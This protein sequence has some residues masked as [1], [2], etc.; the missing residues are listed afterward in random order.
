MSPRA[1]LSPALTSQTIRRATSPAIWTATTS[2]PSGVRITT[3]LR[4]LSSLAAGR[5]A[6]PNRP[7]RCI[8]G[9]HLTADGAR[10]TCAS[11]TDRKM[12]TRGSGI[13]GQS[14]LRRRATAFSIRQT[15]PSAGA[16]TTPGRVGG[17]RGGWRKNARVRRRRT[18]PA[19]LRTSGACGRRRPAPGC[20]RRTAGRPG[21]SGGT[22]ERTSSTTWGARTALAAS[23]GARVW[24]WGIDSTVLSGQV[25]YPYGSIPPSI[26]VTSSAISS[27]QLADAS[28][29]R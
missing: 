16:T 7:G 28:Q 4:S 10:C 8:D 13:V 18:R 11:K 24:P 25:P 14:E 15:W 20:R 22:V 12:L 29:R 3:L 26:S 27:R 9:D 23:A 6:E 1:T 2:T 17:T 5:S 19:V 21:A